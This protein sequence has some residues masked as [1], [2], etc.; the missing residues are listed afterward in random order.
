MNTNL[1]TSQGTAGPAA[2]SGDNSLNH[3]QQSL[4]NQ[5]AASAF[6]FG[7]VRAIIGAF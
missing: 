6:R 3:L 4:A 2:T 5:T 7:L 1:S